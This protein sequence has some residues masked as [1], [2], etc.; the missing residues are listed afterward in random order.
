[1]V[2]WLRALAALLKDQGLFPS[3]H[4]RQLAIDHNSSSRRRGGF[5]W[6]PQAPTY[7]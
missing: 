7:M 1:M 4:I 3:T 5:F 6:P 2:P